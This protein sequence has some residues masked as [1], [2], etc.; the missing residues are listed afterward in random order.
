M[1]AVAS[2]PDNEWIDGQLHA[3]RGRR[4]WDL[5]GTIPTGAQ[6]WRATQMFG[7]P[8]GADPV[9]KCKITALAGSPGSIEFTPFI[10]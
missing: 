4:R 8:T 2:E 10:A 1:I 6:G 9:V 7:F 3:H 5:D